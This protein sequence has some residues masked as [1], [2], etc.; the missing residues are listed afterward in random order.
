MT[1]ALPSSPHWA[2]T[3]TVTGML[4]RSPENWTERA[5]ILREIPIRVFRCIGGFRAGRPRTKPSNAP[6][7][8]DGRPVRSSGVTTVMR[9][10]AWAEMDEAAR[11]A[12]CARG[13]ADIFD[14]DLRGSIA[15]LIEDVRDRG[16]AAVCDAL[17]RF[18]GIVVAPDRLRVTADEIAAATVSAEVDAAIDDAIAHC[19]AFNEQIM[20]RHGDWSFEPEPGLT[21][22]EK[23]T[24]IASVG[25]F[26]PSGKASYPS[27]A[28]Q[29]GAP[30][31]VAGVPSIV[32]RRAADP[33]RRRRRRPGRARRVP[34]ARHR[35]RLPRQ[36]PGRPGR[37]GLRHRVDPQGA[38]DRRARLAGGHV[39]AGR[40]A[41]LRGGDDDGARADRE[42]GDRRRQ[43]RPR[44]PRRRP[45]D[46]GRAR[47][48]LVGRARH[49]VP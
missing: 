8:S 9:R 32:A 7:H 1:L 37:P 39:R 36:R 18:D 17:A 30:A 25:L 46:R 22:G 26:V 20:A 49:H 21:V 28:Y 2:P 47:H 15:S 24:P 41:A 4:Q 23:V 6:K 38:Q 5:W 19:R 45:A 3:T 34:Q 40:A 44:T 16:D 11:A 48:R 13:L 35:R 14:P 31:V 12:L 10:M 29:L 33:R 42:P 43:R 27:V